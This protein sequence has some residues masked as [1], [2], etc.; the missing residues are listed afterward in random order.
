MARRIE[1]I[2][3]FTCGNSRGIYSGAS[4]TGF[5]TSTRDSL[6]FWQTSK[7]P[8]NAVLAG[9]VM[10][11]RRRR[12]EAFEADRWSYQRRNGSDTRLEAIPI[13]L[14]AIATR[15]E[16]IDIAMTCGAKGYVQG[17]SARSGAGWSCFIFELETRLLCS[18]MRPQV[19]IGREKDV[20]AS[21]AISVMHKQALPVSFFQRRPGRDLPPENPIAPFVARP[22]APFVESIR[23]MR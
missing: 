19:H 5:Q 20:R 8:T 2:H 10:W 1:V 16:A 7:R 3:F 13:R 18:F 23:R 4:S 15:V 21:C 6:G 22:G 11:R 17:N 14:E 12:T 9:Q